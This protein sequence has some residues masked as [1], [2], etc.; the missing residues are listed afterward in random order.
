M[1]SKAAKAPRRALF[2]KKKNDFIETWKKNPGMSLR[3]LAA[4]FGCGS[5]QINFIL[6]NKESISELYESSMS[7]TSVLSRERCHDFDCSEVNDVLCC[8]VLHN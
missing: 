5:S 3:A 8:R 1:K 2:L 6:N 7:S 4:K